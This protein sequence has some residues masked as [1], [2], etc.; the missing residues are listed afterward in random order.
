MTTNSI[1]LNSRRSWLFAH[2]LAVVTAMSIVV[3]VYLSLFSNGVAKQSLDGLLGTVWALCV[4]FFYV[5][6]LVDSIRFVTPK[7]PWVWPILVFLLN[8]FG[9]LLYFVLV[10]RSTNRPDAP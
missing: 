1:N 6:M 2:F 4:A 8:V 9:A 10:W 5:W 7:N 3:T